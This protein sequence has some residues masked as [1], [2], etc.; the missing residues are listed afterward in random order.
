MPTASTP[1]VKIDPA[2]VESAR[3]DAG[4]P[5]QAAA[6]RPARRGRHRRGGRRLADTGRSMN[7]LVAPQPDFPGRKA[8]ARRTK[9]NIKLGTQEFPAADAANPSAFALKV[10]RQFTDDE[11]S[12]RIYGS[13]VVIARLTADGV[14]A[15]AAPPEL[16]RPRHSKA[17]ASG[18]AASIPLGKRTLPGRARWPGRPRRRGRRHRVH[19]P[20]ARPLRRGG[21]ARGEMTRAGHVLF[22]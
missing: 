5:R 2:E 9:V 1:S 7:L 18:C 20:A 21:P 14:E 3:R 22:R 17:C 12:L 8:P 15:A 19:G 10:R 4:V 13:E 6:A 16:R 11:R